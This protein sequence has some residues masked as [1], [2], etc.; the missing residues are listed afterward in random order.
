MAKLVG[1]K[2]PRYKT[3]LAGSRGLYC[4]WQNM[5]QRCLNPNHP[6]YT[7]YGGRGI[8]ICPEWIDIKGF[9]DW[10]F[11]SGYQP[12]L[13]I[14]RVDNDKGYSPDNCRWV[15]VSTNSRKKST[16]KL[17]LEQAGE[18]RERL[19]LGENEYELAKEYGVVH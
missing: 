19:D 5:K 6:K 3:G 14:D 10:A 9:R 15:P 13:T 7:R 2:N 12:G 17:T 4:S 18:I 8:E 11:T 16:T 1:D